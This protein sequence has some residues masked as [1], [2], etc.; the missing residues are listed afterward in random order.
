MTKQRL[1][2]SYIYLAFLSE[3]VILTDAL[4]VWISSLFTSDIV[5]RGVVSFI[6]IYVFWI[7]GIFIIHKLYKNN[8]SLHFYHDEKPTYKHLLLGI[9]I[10]AISFTVSYINWGDFKIVSE[11]MYGIR[12][13]GTGIGIAYF[14]AQ[15]IYY[16]LEVILLFN[17]IKFAQQAGELLFDKIKIPYGGIALSLLWGLYHIIPHGIIDGLTTT[18]FAFLM[19]IA[20]LVMRKNQRYAFLLILL[21]FI[22]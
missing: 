13:M 3:L 10:L 19:G 11:L 14:I 16:F 1:V 9:L 7:S 22:L 8:E 15:Y 2:I 18:F 6:L 4:S 17:I 5:L 20:Y 12:N 21:I